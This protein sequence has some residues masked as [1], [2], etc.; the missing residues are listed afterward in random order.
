MDGKHFPTSDYVVGVTVP[1]FHPNCRG[2]TVPYYADLEGYGER[3]A[4]NLDGD[5]FYVPADTT[6]EQWEKMQDE[7]YGDGSVDK[8]R[9]MHY[10]KSADLEQYTR[11]KDVLGSDA[12]DSFEEFQ[13]IKYDTPEQYKDITGYYRYKMENPSS[14]KCF[15]DANKAL[16]MLRESGK[17][18]A[19]GTLVSPPQGLLIVEANQHAKD[20]FIK[21]SITQTDAQNIIS[22]AVFAIKQRQGTQYAFYTEKGY[23]VLRNDGLLTSLGWLDEGGRLLYEEMMKYVK[24]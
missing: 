11:Y 15:Y 7:K 13:Q 9:K 2:T 8:T 18:R 5:V 21:R 1:P 12:P 16:K 14:D 4:R 17:I 24:I 6:Y 23:A 20:T 22:H 10:N 19:T 3:F